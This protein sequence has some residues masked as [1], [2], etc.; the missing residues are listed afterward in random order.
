MTFSWCEIHFYNA[1]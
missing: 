1:G